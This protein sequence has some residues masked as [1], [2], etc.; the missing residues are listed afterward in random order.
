MEASVIRKDIVWVDW[1]KF[2]GMFFVYWCHIGMLCDT[3]FVFCPVPYGPFFVNIFFVVSGYLFFK[4]HLS[5][6]NGIYITPAKQFISLGTGQGGY[7]L[8]SSLK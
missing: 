5:K 6:L 4:K 2:I 1:A 7:F 8:E 3:K